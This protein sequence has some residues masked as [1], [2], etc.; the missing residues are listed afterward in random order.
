MGKAHE[1]IPALGY[2]WLTGFYDLTI[3]V[4]MPERRFRNRL[5]ENLSLKKGDRVLEFGFGTGQNLLLAKKRLQ[6]TEIV[7]LDIDP[8]VKSIAERKLARENL[9]IPLFLYDG[10]VFPFADDYFDTVYSSL[11]FHQLD[12]ATKGQ[13]LKEI[14]RV[15][16]P[17]GLLV[18]GDWGKPKSRLMRFPFYVIQLLDGFATTNDNVRGLM[19][20]FMKKA[21]FRNVEE[22]S[23]LNTA[24]GVYCFYRGNK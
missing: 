9:E 3:R 15:L 8:R 4:T 21:G 1:Y 22:T 18:I 10:K 14:A 11:V 20:V 24:V 19:P 5:I 16:R 12:L 17:N 7:G 23:Y 2:D 6:Q 13:C